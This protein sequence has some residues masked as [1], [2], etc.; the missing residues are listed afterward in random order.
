MSPQAG[1]F[2]S[3]TMNLSRG[4]GEQYVKG[5]QLHT[6]PGLLALLSSVQEC[7]ESQADAGQ[8]PESS[9]I[10]TTRVASGAGSHPFEFEGTVY[11]TGPYDGAPFGLSIVTHVAA[12]PFNLG[13]VVVRARIDI[14]SQDSTATITTDES[15]PYPCRRSCSGCPCVRADHGRHR[16]VGF[17]VQPDR[18]RSAADHGQDLRRAGG[19]CE[20]A[21]PI[22][23]RW[24]RQS[25]LRTEIQR[26]DLGP[27]QSGAWSKL[28]REA[29]VPGWGARQRCQRR[30]GQ[31]RPTA[32]V[33]LAADDATESLPRGDVCGQSRGMSCGSIVGIARART[34]CCLLNQPVPPISCPTA[35][36]PSP[37]WLSCCR[38]TA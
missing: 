38:G 3:F 24:L 31:G 10:G 37:H 30:L 1:Q 18:L 6:P 27:H 8:C 32:A 4:D 11:L 9:K 25:R 34:P 29:F 7:A 12:G 2:S 19:D 28:G 36:K 14:D 21:E 22:R 35:A 26:V 16:P 20:L 23:G 5:I 13:L 17:H 15:G 33:A